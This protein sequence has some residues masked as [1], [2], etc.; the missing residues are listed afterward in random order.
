MSHLNERSLSAG[1]FNQFHID[2]HGYGAFAWQ[3]ELLNRIEAERAW[4][5][6]LDL[7]TGAGKTSC[8]DIAL[9]ALA[10][11]A[12]R[13]PQDRW[14][15]RRIAMVVD[16]RIVVDQ[17][18]E[19]GRKL[20]QSLAR[21]D[22]P[23]VTAAVA[24]RLKS[25]VTPPDT[26]A[27]VE[28]IGVFTLRG[29]IPRDDG[30]ARSPDQPLV[31]ASTVDQL[32]SR[33]LMQ[34][35]GV[36]DSMKPVHAG[37][38][39]NDILILLDE[40][41]LSKAFAD[42]LDALERMRGRHA[43]TGIDTRFHHA[44]L[45]ATPDKSARSTFRLDLA[46][47]QPGSPLHQRLH[48]PKPVRL[49]EAASDAHERTCALEAVKLSERHAAVAV[50]VNRVAAASRITS[51]IR[52]R[53]DSNTKV[54]LLTGR[55]RPLDRDDVLRDLDSLIRAGRTRNEEQRVVVVATQCIEAGA[56]FDFDALVTEAASLSALRQRFGRLDRL[57]DYYASGRKAEG[58]IVRNKGLK[59][60]PV[61]GDA[62]PNTWAW[63]KQVMNG[64]K[65]ID[66]GIVA[67]PA[68]PPDE[69]ASL[70]DNGEDPRPP[71]MLPAYL[72]L[73]AQT[74][75]SPDE[76]PDVAL[77]LHGA[78]EA[79]AEVQVVWR[80]DISNDLLQRARRDEDA[81]GQLIS[82]ISAVPPSSLEAL[83]IPLAAARRWLRQDEP[84]EIADVEV[85]VDEDYTAG[86][87]SDLALLW[88]GERSDVVNAARLR[89]GSTIIVPAKRGG[90]RDGSF[91]PLSTTSVADWAERAV[92]LGRGR[93]VLRLHKAVLE[94]HRLPASLL[95]TDDVVGVLADAEPGLAPWEK[96]W[97]HTLRSARLKH[98]VIDA[99]EYRTL[100]E[101]PRIPA[102]QLRAQLHRSDSFEDGA[103]HTSDPETSVHRG[104]A[105][106][107]DEHCGAVGRLARAYATSAGLPPE[108]VSDITLAGWLH[109]I[110]K[111]DPRFQLLL[112]GGDEIRQ[113]RAEKPLAKSEMTRSERFAQ[114][115]ARQ[116]SGYP[117]GGRH[118]LQSIA[119]IEQNLEFVK[120]K[121]N[122]LDLVLHLIASHHGHC[123]PFAPVVND[124]EPAD[125]QV[126]MSV[127]EF[128]TVA[129][130]AASPRQDW[131]RIDSPIADRFWR[132]VER[133]GWLEL[134]WFE[135]ILRL[136]DHRASE[137]NENP[138]QR[139]AS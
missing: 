55:M 94:Q 110:G 78:V 57:G 74:S 96:V 79:P 37:L 88:N 104:Y 54:V 65:E 53:V 67:L 113:L 129:L 33:L 123:R 118:E 20:L 111:V 16:R 58:V 10:L 66:F 73:W 48:A 2:V 128:G 9:F 77:W 75:P 31:I 23:P 49:V 51:D 18:A 126:E 19:R 13:E 36:T 90:I 8:I 72:D 115:F 42:T 119:L 69:L 30:W 21:P 124:P 89:P 59:N 138:E 40:V 44:F 135:S 105:Q 70:N 35:Y 131:H 76:A 133:Y 6:V 32:G 85:A 83:S 17:V 63:L 7:P 87:T 136:A 84:G 43:S 68:P 97:L 11:D 45:S 56:D 29:G 27:P 52:G 22:A 80:C 122:D 28:P 132:V 106:L 61:Y 116:K 125:L 46:Q 1:D 38:A 15:P 109:D 139:S 71:V 24:E 107:L 93:A 5:R 25:L 102:A 39:A 60:D 14:C 86:A 101:S 98:V 26:G 99:D 108:T 134:C 100:L 3:Q 103:E 82:T 12:R 34:G 50:V 127:G 137:A 91:D 117:R 4:P 114:R 95:D 130:H 92:L 64:S 62:T 121:A 120:S 41:H 112:H 81:L 47:I